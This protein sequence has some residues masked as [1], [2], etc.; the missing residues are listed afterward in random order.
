M[1]IYFTVVVQSCRCADHDALPVSLALLVWA[2]PP[3]YVFNWHP[4]L[5]VAGVVAETQGKQ[6]ACEGCVHDGTAALAHTPNCWGLA[7]FDALLLG[8]IYKPAVPF[9]LPSR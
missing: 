8:G 2:Q 1:Y 7:A 5:M 9:G 3:I 6:G 4:L